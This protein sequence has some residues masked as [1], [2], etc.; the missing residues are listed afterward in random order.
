VTV[1]FAI[2]R[3]TGTLTGATVVTN[4]SGVATLGGWV[5]G[6]GMNCLSATV[7]A[8]GVAGSPVGFIATGIPASGPGYEISVQYL[9]CVTASQEAAFA[10]AVTRW[11]GIITG[12]VADLSNV[13]LSP[14]LCGS[15]APGLLNRNI[16]DLLIFATIEPIDGP[17]KILGSAG[18]CFIRIPGN[19]PVIGLM[20]FDVADIDMLEASGQLTNVILHEMGHVIGIGSLWSLFG[21]LQQASPV[22]GPPLDTYDNGAGAIA[23]FDAIGGTTYTQ[24]NKAP[25]ENMFSSG[26]INAHWRESVLANELM[27]GFLNGSGPNPLSLLTVRSLADFGYTINPAAADPFFLT[28]ALRANAPPEVLIRL[29]DD[30]FAGPLYTIDGRGRLLRVR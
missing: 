29:Q 24:G 28:L 6:P 17:G 3:G 16:D 21:L 11:A 22:G 20:R 18:P 14:G 8:P 26:T 10:N 9:S 30:V 27:T 1:N 4:S 23:G 25:V 15:N 12:D 2:T 19:L 13:S 7:A 5:L